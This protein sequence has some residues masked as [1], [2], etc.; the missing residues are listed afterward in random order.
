LFASDA[1]D[2][3]STSGEYRQ[4]NNP[5]DIVPENRSNRPPAPERK[6]ALFQSLI[7][8]REDA[9]AIRWEGRN[10]RSGNS[11][12]GAVDWLRAA[13]SRDQ[14]NGVRRSLQDAIKRLRSPDFERVVLVVR[15][16]LETALSI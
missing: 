11:P 8:G 15:E 16:K 3:N 6:I 5:G 1:G 12:A 9:Y 7:R 4:T 2:R 14:N 10:G 13:V